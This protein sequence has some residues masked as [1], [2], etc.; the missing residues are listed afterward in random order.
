VTTQ[1]H[2]R[3]IGRTPLPGDNVA[4]ATRRL[5][6]NTHIETDSGSFR[7]SHTVLEGH[8]FTLAP[9][10]VGE[11]LLSWELPFGYAC[12]PL[13]PGDYVCN[14]A[15]LN[16]L[17]E[18]SID[19]VL[20]DEANFEDQI[21]PYTL[22]EAAFRP[23]AQ[24]DRAAEDATFLGYRRP[25]QRGVGTRNMIVLLGTTS[26]TGSF[27]RRLAEQ[28]QGRADEFANVDGIVAVAHTEGADGHPN[29]LELLL[30][31]LAGFIV[32][33]NVGAIL[34]VDYG[35]E[36]VTNAMLSAYMQQNGYALDQ[37]PHHFLS[38]TES[39]A[40]GLQQAESIAAD[41]LPLVNLTDRTAQPLGELK[42]A[43]QCGGSDAFSGISGNPLASWVAREVIR[44]G[45]SANLAETDELIGAES[46]V[47]QKVANLETAKR[48]IATVERFKEWASWHD[49][50]AEGNPSGGNKYRGLYNITLKSI[51]AAMKRHPDVRLDGV[52]DYSEP[53]AQPGYYFMDSPGNDLE[54]I[55]GQVASGCNMIF[56]VTG[57]GSIT[58]FPFVPTV[59]IV[60]TSAR[61]QLLKDDM[62]VNAGAYLDGTAMDDLGQ[63]LLERTLDVA[64]GTQTVGERA[65]HAQVQI[66]RNWRRTGPVETDNG[67][68][69]P[70]PTGAPLPVLAADAGSAVLSDFTFPAQSAPWGEVAEQV[71]LILPTSL[72]SGQIARLTANHLNRIELGK[73][74]GISRYV[75]LVHTEGCGSSDAA[76]DLSMQSLMAYVKHPSVR[77]CLFLEHGCEKTHNDFSHHRLLE[78]GLDPDSFG[79]ASVQL[80]GG[81]ERVVEKMEAWFAQRI[82]EMAP[83]S[84]RS[85]P[86]TTRSLGLLTAGPIADSAAEALSRLT[87][88]WVADGGTLLVPANDHLLVADAYRSGVLASGLFDRPTVDYAVQPAESGLHVM[89]TPTGH[90]VE[91]LVGLGASGAELILAYV[92]S[93]PMQGHPLLPVLQITADGEVYGAYGGDIDLLLQGN[94]A[95]W[96]RLI[97]ERL[98]ATLAG[99]YTPVL[100]G[101]GN[102]DFQLTRGLIGISL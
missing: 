35:S 84:V 7:L 81:I 92:G 44:H 24:I 54:S 3:E 19:F 4:I 50:T 20:P 79:W 98:A 60:T 89:A 67:Q 94:S 29:N 62:D 47:L 45:G 46:Y 38:L 53:M 5:E 27:V 16:A 68:P 72:C 43:L 34:A 15:M 85:L 18:R 64:A 86:V 9:I 49:T 59:K 11:S 6:A 52:I 30:R 55:A 90:W 26:R 40:G 36:A 74:R 71:G 37:V 28:M 23:V 102:V 42:I 12:R 82:A 95:N 77:H 87:G 69:S 33:P 31:T 57:N 91:K 41:W 39:F 76:S 78:M 101:R 80:D 13:E 32:H 93:E 22:D 58:N 66:W 56:F 51:G 63:E 83:S 73:E 65:G 2:L 17:S 10:A 21:A 1:Y 96:P 70:T 88:R 8:R 14:T 100:I 25:G 99:E 75:A 97:G 61:Y 48:F